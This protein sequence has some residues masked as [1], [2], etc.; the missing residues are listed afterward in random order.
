MRVAVL[1]SYTIE[2]IEPVLELR[3]RLEGYA[4]EFFFGGY[5]QYVQEILDPG[6]AF[7]RFEPDVVLLCLRVEEL[8]PDFANAF[9]ETDADWPARMTVKANEIAS[10]VETLRA[11]SKAQVLVQNLIAPVDA[12]WGIYDAQLAG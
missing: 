12:Y 11:N 1:R 7:Y 5:D 6:S 4:P 8:D 9:G 10:L 3:L 2:A